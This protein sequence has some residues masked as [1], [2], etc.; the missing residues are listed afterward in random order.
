MTVFSRVHGNNRDRSRSRSRSPPSDDRKR[1]PRGRRSHFGGS[2]STG[3]G[4]PTS[5]D[6]EPTTTTTRGGSARGGRFAGRGGKQHKDAGK[7][8]KRHNNNFDGATTNKKNKG[9]QIGNA[10]EEDPTLKEARLAKRAARFQDHLDEGS[11]PDSQ[12]PVSFGH[13]KNKKQ[14]SGGVHSRLSLGGLGSSAKQHGWN[15]NSFAFAMGGDEGEIDWSSFAIKG[16]SATVEKKYLRLTAAPDPT[17]VRPPSVLRKALELAKKNWLEKGDY[18]ATCDAFK[19]IRQDLTVQC[20]RDAFTVQVYETHARVAVEKRDKEEFNMCLTQLKLLHKT[21]PSQYVNEFACYR[22]LYYI[23]TK[24]TLDMGVFIA[25][26]S[27]ALKSDPCIK[28]ALEVRSAWASGNYVRF[29]RLYANAPNM[30]SA[31]MDFF[32]ERERKEAFGKV[33]RSYRP[34]ISVDQLKSILAFE[35]VSRVREFLEQ[36]IGDEVVYADRP[37]N[38]KIDCKATS[39]AVA[40]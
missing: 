28:H 22:L 39:A 7:S 32:M 4:S 18:H 15:L 24:N 21:Y 37:Q 12:L 5:D 25:S 14:K 23:Y 29:F 27:P 11:S 20:I 36:V 40:L 33:V 9:K 16:T 3:S 26:M 38:E 17:T 2:G 31:L 30:S 10:P 19:S 13:K 8:N 6:D 35:D 34:T 1:T